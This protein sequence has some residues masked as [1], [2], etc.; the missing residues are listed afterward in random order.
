MRDRRISP[1]GGRVELA[2]LVAPI[3]VEVAVF[4]N[5]GSRAGSQSVRQHRLEHLRACTTIR[6]E[7]PKD[8]AL[9]AQVDYPGNPI[10][11]KTGPVGK[12]QR[13]GGLPRWT[14]RL[15]TS[16]RVLAASNS[17]SRFRSHSAVAASN[18]APAPAGTLRM[19]VPIGRANSS[20]E[21]VEEA[22][23]GG[24]FI[25]CH[26]WPRREYFGYSLLVERTF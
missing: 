24:V 7:K 2:M 6:I 22:S 17:S 4:D 3:W 26:L 9:I 23:S 18:S 20:V 12:C 11:T 1:K 8:R 19:P 5:R 13:G 16:P 15:S 14:D 10:I 21:S 25:N